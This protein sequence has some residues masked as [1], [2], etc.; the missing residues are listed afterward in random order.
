MG[1]GE[2]LGNWSVENGKRMH[3]TD[4]DVWQVDL[5]VNAGPEVELEY[6]Y[7]VRS[8]DGGALYWKPGDNCQ[9]KVP[10][11]LREEKAIA[12][13]VMVRDAWDGSL[14]DIELEV[15]GLEFTRQ[16]F[17][18]EQERAAVESAV[19]RALTELTQAMSSSTNMQQHKQDPTAPEVLQAD[20]LVAAAARKAVAMHR[21]LEAS[22][23]MQQL[24]G[25]EHH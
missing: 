11:W 23:T 12:E 9:I 5:E 24:P 1:S 8:E 10:V 20:R 6:K 7:V 13:G 17:T 25:A 2:A 19:D 15:T 18:E 4:G 21:A 3:W 14:Q 22:R 16:E